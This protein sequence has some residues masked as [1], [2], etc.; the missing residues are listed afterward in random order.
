MLGTDRCIE[1]SSIYHIAYMFVLLLIAIILLHTHNDQVRWLASADELAKLRET[2][3]KICFFTSHHIK[4][5]SHATCPTCF[6]LIYG[7]LVV[8]SL[9]KWNYSSES[10]DR[11]IL[12][13]VFSIF[14]PKYENLFCFQRVPEVSPWK[15]TAINA[16]TKDFMRKQL[17]RS[18]F[19]DVLC[20][21]LS[22]LFS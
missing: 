9:H 22:L 3:D 21:H 15:I 6:I 13:I 18:D 14:F 11:M 19:F 1:E 20:I 7:H 5:A 12:H 4:S 8:V 2:I 17:V 10:D 16:I